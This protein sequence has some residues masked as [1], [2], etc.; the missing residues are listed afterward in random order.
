MGDWRSPISAAIGTGPALATVTAGER[1]EPAPGCGCAGERGLSS[2]G[3]RRPRRGCPGRPARS[4]SPWSPVTK[5]SWLRMMIS[6]TSPTTV[7]GRRHQLRCRRAAF[8]LRP[9]RRSKLR[10]TT[11]AMRR[12]EHSRGS[13]GAA[14]SSAVCR[15]CAASS[16]AGRCSCRITSPPCASCELDD[17][18]LVPGSITKVVAQVF[19]RDSAMSGG[20]SSGR[21]LVGRRADRDVRRRRRWSARR[22]ETA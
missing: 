7:V 13:R 10:C 19:R 8:A 17:D 20:S 22:C 9:P 16:P 18:D 1:I 5:K 21:T 15:R 6:G 11:A 12:S 4:R 3:S 2:T 14:P